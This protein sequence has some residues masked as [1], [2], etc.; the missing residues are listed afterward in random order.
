MRWFLKFYCDEIF[1]G[2]NTKNIFIQDS[3]KSVFN[4]IY[5]IFHPFWVKF[6][7][8]YDCLQREGSFS[9][10]AGKFV[11]GSRLISLLWNCTS[12]SRFLSFTEVVLKLIWRLKFLICCNLILVLSNVNVIYWISEDD[13]ACKLMLRG[14]S[15]LYNNIISNRKLQVNSTYTCTVYPGYE[16]CSILPLLTK[17]CL[18]S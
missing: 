18:P 12:K 7:F 5:E 14:Y 16:T 9:W 3:F 11:G 15:M 17:R 2:Y 13:R 10:A 1:F 8:L 6:Y 4:I